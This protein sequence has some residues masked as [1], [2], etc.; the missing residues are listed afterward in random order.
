MVMRIVDL[1]PPLGEVMAHTGA[2]VRGAGWRAGPTGLHTLSVRVTNF[3]GR[4]WLEASLVAEPTEADW[5]IVPL[6]GRERLD[7]PLTGTA[8]QS[9]NLGFTFRLN[10]LWLRGRMDR[11][12]TAAPEWNE[13]GLVR[14]GRLEWMRVG[15]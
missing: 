4:V 13:F 11:A 1:L 15:F 6:D 2:P 9:V 14:R 8:P 10:S 3:V 7:F 5:F 12:G